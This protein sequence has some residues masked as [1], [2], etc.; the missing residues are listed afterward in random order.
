M[1]VINPDKENKVIIVNCNC[2]CDEQI[3]IR[4]FDDNESTEYFLSICEPV[5][6][7][8]QNGI[9]KTIKNRFKSCWRIL[10]GKEYL[11]C[12]LSLNKQ[13]IKELEN[14]LKEIQEGD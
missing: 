14:K 12:D 8:K 10:R 9:F 7:T 6:Y 11:L 2:G 13:Q 3:N 1:V 5:F 4:R